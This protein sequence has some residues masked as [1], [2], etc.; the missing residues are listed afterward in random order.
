MIM[1]EKDIN[2]LNEETQQA[3]E[4][5]AEY[6]DGYMGEGNDFVEVL[7]WPAFE[8]LLDIKPGERI[9]DIACGN[10]LT[11]RRLAAMG[12]EVT[13]FDFSSKMI[14][15]AVKHSSEFNDRIKYYLI[16]ATNEASLLSLGNGKFAAAI[17]NMALFDMAQINPL[18][19]ALSKLL[20]P[21]CTFVFSMMHPCFNNPYVRLT[22]EMDDRSGKVVTEYSIRIFQYLTSGFEY[23]VALKDQPQKQLYFH[24]P[25]QELFQA[26]FDHGFVVDGLEERAFPPDHPPGS[27]HLTWNGNFSEIPPVMVIRMRLL[28]S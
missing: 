19:N 4:E 8:R 13:A 25:L 27:S 23:G 18:F 6:W 20:V 7:C 5:N 3:W 2:K 26:G 16:D 28:Q 24:R 15:N 14:E 22:A 12:Y 21:G 1:K 17:S 9:L 10:G 11:S